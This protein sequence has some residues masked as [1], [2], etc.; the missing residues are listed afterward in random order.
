MVQG[1]LKEWLSDLRRCLL[2][3][4]EWAQK[5]TKAKVLVGNGEEWQKYAV[6]RRREAFSLM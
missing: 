6:A 1:G 4:E 3:V 2:P 5:V